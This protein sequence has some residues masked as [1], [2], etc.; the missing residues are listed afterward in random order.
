MG[1]IQK[2]INDQN[3]VLKAI[4]R[5]WKHKSKT[6]SRPSSRASA[7]SASSLGSLPS[8]LDDDDDDADSVESQPV[9]HFADHVVRE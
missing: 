8:E 2:Q 6:S 9:P 3:A 1:E 5:K 7:A 4:V